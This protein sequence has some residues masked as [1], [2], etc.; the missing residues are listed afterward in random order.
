M[1][2]LWN[3]PIRSPV[4]QMKRLKLTREV[5]CLSESFPRE[6]GDYVAGKGVQRWRG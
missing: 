3:E 5:E 1:I 2:C 4:L 6:D